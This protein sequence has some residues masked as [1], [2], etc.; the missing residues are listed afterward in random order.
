MNVNDGTR[1]NHT[2]PAGTLLTYMNHLSM[3]RDDRNCS[4]ETTAAAEKLLYTILVFQSLLNYGWLYACSNPP[5]QNTLLVS[6]HD[7][8]GVMSS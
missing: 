3:R 4:R 2:V 8:N 1:Y 6:I 7:K 5:E